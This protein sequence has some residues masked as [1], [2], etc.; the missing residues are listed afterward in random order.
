VAGEFEQRRDV[1]CD[2][3]GAISGLSCVRPSGGP[4]LFLNVSQLRG[5]S[6]QISHVLLER[7]G[8]PTTPGVYFHSSEHVRMAFGG[9][10]GVLEEALGRLECAARDLQA[11]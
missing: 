2:G 5:D 9:K 6:Q 8:I 11:D 1:G 4:F 3:I 7:Y 10:T